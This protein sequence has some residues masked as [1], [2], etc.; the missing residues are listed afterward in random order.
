MGKGF[1]TPTLLNA[2]LPEVDPT[3]RE[4]F[5]VW[6]VALS[7]GDAIRSMADE[8]TAGPDSLPVELLNSMTP[9]SLST[10]LASLYRGRKGWMSRPTATIRYCKQLQLNVENRFRF[11]SLSLFTQ[12]IFTFAHP[13]DSNKNGMF[14]LFAAVQGDRPV[15][16]SVGGGYP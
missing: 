10:S 14:F 13:H 6:R 2:K 1:Q 11:C 8:K 3:N 16:F 12:G 5:P 15:G 4:Q 9:L 7:L